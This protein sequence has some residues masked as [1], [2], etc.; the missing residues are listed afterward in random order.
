MEALQADPYG[1]VK[2]RVSYFYDPEVGNYH[3]GQGHPFKVN[4]LCS[5][6]R[7]TN[8]CDQIN[9]Y[10]APP[11]SYDAQPYCELRIVPQNGLFPPE[12]HHSLSNDPFPF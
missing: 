2:R 4:Q 9:Q 1:T 10:L 3:Y 12:A 8:L 5:H 11:S 6:A 7:A